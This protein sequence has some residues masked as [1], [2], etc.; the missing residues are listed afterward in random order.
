MRTKLWN[1]VGKQNPA[2]RAIRLKPLI[3]EIDATLLQY[4]LEKQAA[5]GNFKGGYGFAPMV[6]SLDYSRICG[7]GEI[8]AALLHLGNKGANSAKVHIEVLWWILAVLPDDLA[9]E[10]RTLQ[11][12]LVLV[13]F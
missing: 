6:D 4:H 11:C 7:T 5:A 1:A 10:D 13:H 3:I 9:Q 2:K 8:L 12:E